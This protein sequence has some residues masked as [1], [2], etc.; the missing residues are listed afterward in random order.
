MIVGRA[1]EMNSRLIFQKQITNQSG[2]IKV[3][4]WSCCN[5]AA[6]SSTSWSV[7]I[8]TGKMAHTL[9]L[10]LLIQSQINVLFEC[11]W[12]E[13]P[14][15]HLETYLQRSMGRHTGRS[16]EYSTH[17][18]CQKA[19]RMCWDLSCHRFCLHI[20]TYRWTSLTSSFSTLPI[21]DN[22]VFLSVP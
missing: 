7:T 15:S 14:K 19:R 12:V 1:E 16:L 22:S 11:I 3:R 8:F 21:V 13:E 5:L 2:A 20:Y 4:C 18:H 10:S 17:S 9:T 6:A